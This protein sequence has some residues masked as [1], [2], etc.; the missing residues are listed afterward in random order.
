MS[1][2]G[3]LVDG[4]LHCGC[5][6][7]AR[8]W[9]SRQPNGNRSKWFSN[10]GKGPE[11]KGCRFF[12]WDHEAEQRGFA[13]PKDSPIEPDRPNSNTPSKRQPS[14]ASPSTTQTGA[15]GLNRKRT[16]SISEDPNDEHGF[17]QSDDGLRQ[18]KIKVETPPV[19]APP[20]ETPRKAVKISY[21]A[22]PTK[23][24]QTSAYGLE[25]PQTDRRP[26]LDPFASRYPV[27]SGSLFT[28]SQVNGDGATQTAT[29]SSSFETSTPSRYRN[30]P[31]DDLV[32]DVVSLLQ[33]ANVP[34]GEETEKDLTSMLSKHARSAEGYK[35]VT[36][37]TIKAK[38]A[39]ITDLTQ[40]VSALEIELEAEKS[41][42]ELLQLETEQLD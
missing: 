10:C 20:V 8:R 34:I 11:A 35:R 5:N 23:A 22:T 4:V 28:P 9:R 18:V 37:A 13:L 38:N 33:R 39:K 7:P 16:R 21:D 15:L 24:R 32:R 17:G 41:T 31:A 1:G 42:V 25:T 3:Q 36:Q 30:V 26:D 14:P 6:L 2:N 40:R 29:P 19:D 27:S 12:L